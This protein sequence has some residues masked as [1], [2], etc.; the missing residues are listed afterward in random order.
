MA[1]IGTAYINIVPKAPGIEQNVENLL[2]GGAAGGAA[3]KAGAS[4][5]KQLL[6]GLAKL[7]IGAA[8]AKTLRDAL[9]AGGNLQ[10]SYG[11]LDTIYGKAAEGATRYA[12]EAAKAG[13]S[14]NSYAEQ[15]VSFG[16]ALRQAY[17]GDTQA[18]MEAANLAIL[19]MA[20]NSAK[21]GTDLASIQN[22]YQG[23]AKQNYTMLDN[24]FDKMGALA[25]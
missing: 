13:I 5:G 17:G 23:F 1:D 9:S 14:M 2:G 8:A 20:D 3:Q 16:A 25:A 15:A 7:G 11:G 4:L 22:A 18:A 21:M 6:G 10:Q 24:L 19:D 12:Q